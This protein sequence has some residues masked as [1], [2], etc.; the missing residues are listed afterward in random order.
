[1]VVDQ[2]REYLEHGNDPQRGELPRRRHAARVAVPRRD[3]QRQRAEHARADLHRDGAAPGST[4]TTCSTSPRARWPTRWSTSTARVPAEAHRDAS[5]ASRACSRCAILPAPERRP[6]ERSRLDRRPAIARAPARRDRPHRRR[7]RRSCS[8]SAPRLARRDRH[9]QG[10]R[11]GLPAGARGA[12]AAARWRGERRPAA[13][14]RRVG[15]HLRRDHLGLPRARGSG[16]TVAYLGPAGTFSEMA[17]AKHFGACRATRCRCASIDEVFRAGRRRAR[18][19]SASCRWRT[20][21]RARS[22]ARSTSCSQTPLQI[23]GEVVLRVHQNL[24]AKARFA[25]RPSSAS[26]RTPSRSRSATQWLD[27]QPA[28]RRARAGGRATPRR[29][30]SPPRSRTRVRD[31]AGDRGRALRPDDLLAREHRGRA[32]TTR[33]ASSCSATTSPRRSGRDKTSLVMSAPQ[34]AG[35]GARAAHAV[36]R[37]TASA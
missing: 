7:D 19:S 30:G 13:R 32:A 25:R 31:R 5:A 14:R 1:M 22:A 37:S 29:R 21:P 16:C 15:A 10:R 34:P 35:R 27:R 26:T 11:A 9:A 20:P 36:R 23:C 4:S 28:A 8:T 12:G 33:R 3:R 18:R 24:M 2:V 17:V 6:C